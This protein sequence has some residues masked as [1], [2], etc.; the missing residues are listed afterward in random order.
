MQLDTYADAVRDPSGQS[1]RTQLSGRVARIDQ[2]SVRYHPSKDPKERGVLVPETG[3]A[4]QRSVL[5]FRQSR[6]HHGKVV[7]WIVRLRE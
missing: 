1:D 4:M 3:G 7:G 2:I 5:I 6:G